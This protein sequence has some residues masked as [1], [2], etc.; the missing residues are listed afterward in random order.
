M[1]IRLCLGCATALF[2][3]SLLAG[4]ATSTMSLSVD[5]LR[6]IRIERIDFR[7]AEEST[8]SWEKQELAYVE[9]IKASLAPSSGQGQWRPATVQDPKSDTSEYDAL[10]KSPEAQLHLRGLLEKKL[11]DRLTTKLLSEFQGTRPVVLDV[12]IHA[13]IIPGPVQRVV[14]GGVPILGAVT[15]LRDAQTN[16][17]LAKLDRAAAGSAGNGILGVLV[18]Q[19][20][21]DLEDRV[22]DAYVKNLREWLY[23]ERDT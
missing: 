11:R 6:S 9:A 18:D 17:E 23:S 2:I 16:K 1:R 7:Y 3:F 12:E 5:E 20:F 4:C 22:F 19:G 10:V 8:I 14:L 21:D 13:F 15:I